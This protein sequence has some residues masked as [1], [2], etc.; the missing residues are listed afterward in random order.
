MKTYNYST[1]EELGITDPNDRMLL[2]MM[3]NSMLDDTTL[4]SGKNIKA[5]QAGD[6]VVVM[7]HQGESVLVEVPRNEWRTVKE[8]SLISPPKPKKS[9]VQTAFSLLMR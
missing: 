9:W 2:G 5:S 4:P 3:D 7:H 1:L 8:A 6:V